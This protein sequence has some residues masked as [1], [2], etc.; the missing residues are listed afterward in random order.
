MYTARVSPADLKRRVHQL[1]GW[2]E[3]E[4]LAERLYYA[5]TEGGDTVGWHYANNPSGIT[6]LWAGRAKDCLSVAEIVY[7][8]WY[9]T[10]GI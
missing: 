9:M 1:N 5:P 10:A 8:K 6:T 2:L 3:S 4:G 7:R